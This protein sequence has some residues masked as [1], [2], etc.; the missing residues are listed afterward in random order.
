MAGMLNKMHVKTVEDLGQWKF[1]QAAKAIVVLAEKEEAGKRAADA[2]ANI[3]HI[4][5]KAWESKSFKEIAEAPPSAFQG[6]ASWVD[7]NMEVAHLSTIAKLADWKYA[8]WA[9]AIST[10]AKFETDGGSA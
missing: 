6:L 5:D 2:T 9:E 4:L 7:D 3:N 1:Y 10:L 8:K